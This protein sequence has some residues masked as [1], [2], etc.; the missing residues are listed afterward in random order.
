[1]PQYLNGRDVVSGQEGEAYM[2]IDGAV[3]L[4]FAVRNIRATVTKQK[5]EIRTLGRRGV[6]HKTNG[7]SGTGSMEIFYV[8]S[9]FLKMIKQYKD[10]GR[11]TYF[12]IQTINDDPTTT[13]GRQEVT[14]IDVNLDS[15]DIA[16]LDAEN[17]TLT[18]SINFTFD[19]FDTGEMFTEPALGNA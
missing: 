19:D 2:T 4:M 8:T 5:T 13:V 1:M 15:V 16:A 12:D 9:D 11:D 7:W 3:K 10:T 14:L 17:D 6:Q 18:Q